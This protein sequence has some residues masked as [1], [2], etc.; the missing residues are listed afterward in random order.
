[1]CY[2]ILSAWDQT[3]PFPSE[4]KKAWEKIHHNHRVYDGAIPLLTCYTDSMTTLLI[5]A[6]KS[7]IKAAS[8]V[9]KAGLPMET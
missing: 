8:V 9:E 5:T 1:M 7:K 6:C 2:L 3:L 4:K